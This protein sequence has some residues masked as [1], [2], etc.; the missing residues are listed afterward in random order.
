MPVLDGGAV[1]VSGA[2]YYKQERR[3]SVAIESNSQPTK[4]PCGLARLGQHYIRIGR[5]GFDVA[6]CISLS[7]S[8]VQA[9]QDEDAVGTSSM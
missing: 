9:K 2:Y 3:G 6:A 1:V 4:S 8:Y 7:T 5:C